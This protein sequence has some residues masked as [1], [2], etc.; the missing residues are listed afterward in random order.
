MSMQSEPYRCRVLVRP[1]AE[2]DIPRLIELGRHFYEQTAYRRVPY[3]EKGAAGWYRL[4]LDHG[5]L[6]VATDDEALV[7]VIG[8]MS[9]PFLI[10][11]E[12]GVG[13]ELLMWVEPEYR[14]SGAATAL[15]DAIEAAAK[16]LGLTYWSMMCL[17][18]VQPDVAANLYKRRGYTLAE[19]TFVKE[20]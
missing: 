17:E 14:K 12:H 15:M 16:D 5:L 4:M 11:P 20:L 18:A 1:A 19:H 13:T 7:G 10:N 8:G 6:F 3:S 9:S 2:T